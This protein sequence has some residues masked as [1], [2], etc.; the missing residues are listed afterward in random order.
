VLHTSAGRVTG[1]DLGMTPQDGGRDV[2]GILEGIA[3]GDVEFVY[4]LNADETS[5]E[6][7]PGTFVLYQGH[8][9]DRGAHLADVILPGSAYTEKDALW[10]NT[11]G[12]VQKA[13]RAIFPP[14]DA[15]EDW[16]I[17][18]AL[19]AAMGQTLP[20]DT[21]TELRKALFAAHPSFGSINNAPGASSGRFDGAGGTIESGVIAP[22]VID[23]YLTNAI[24][25]SSKT[26]AECARV[27]GGAVAQAAE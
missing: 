14:G 9:G 10:V 6:K 24:A 16:A 19:S 4:L 26:M 13:R 20:F 22:A 18:R 5:F 2:A 27:F 3:S 7:T 25:R 21:Q 23:Y 1:L 15:K 8:H 11:E 12:R 17:I